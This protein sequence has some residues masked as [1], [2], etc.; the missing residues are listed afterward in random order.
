MRLLRLRARRRRRAGRRARRTR[1]RAPWR[2]RDAPRAGAGCAPL[3]LRLPCAHLPLVLI[4]REVDQVDAVAPAA[5]VGAS[6]G[7][8]LL[9]RDDEARYLGRARLEV[10]RGDAA[11]CSGLVAREGG[12]DAGAARVCAQLPRETAGREASEHS[13]L[14]GGRAPLPVDPARR[15]RSC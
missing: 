9:A 3:W 5:E 14:A 13:L 2:G 7:V 8:G 4:V 1:A 15:E 12:V 11:S 10:D 6:V